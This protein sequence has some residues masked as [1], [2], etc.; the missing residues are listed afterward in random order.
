MGKEAIKEKPV[1]QKKLIIFSADWCKYCQYLKKDL[2]SFDLSEYEVEIV[3]VDKK[4]EL[5][6]KYKIQS[7]PTSIILY[8]DVEKSRMKGYEKNKYS[9]WLKK[10]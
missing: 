4:N 10:Q 8:N 9:N 5:S 2:S 1:L 7:L 6:K 3:D